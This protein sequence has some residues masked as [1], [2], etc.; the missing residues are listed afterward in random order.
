M[1]FAFRP[2]T[3]LAALVAGGKVSPDDL[4]G[5]FRDRIRRY[6][7]SLHAFITVM[8][9]TSATTDGPLAGIPYACKDMIQARGAPT[10]AGSRVLADWVP[11]DDADVVK[12]M[13]AAGAVLLGKNNQHEFAY[14]ATGENPHYGT[15]PNPY[16]LTRLAGGSSS[17]SAAAVA[18]GLVPAALGTDTG[19]SVRVPAALCGIVGFKPTL[20]LVSTEGVVPYCWTLDHVGTLTRTVGDAALLLAV[21]TGSDVAAPRPVAGMRIGLPRRHFFAHVDT[22]IVAA[23]RRVLT[24]LEGAGA[25]LVE[26]DL[27]AMDHAR[28]VSLTVQLP[29]ALSYHSRYLDSHREDYG[30]DILAGLASGQ[31]ILAEHY[32]RAKRFIHHYRAET[33]KVL[34]E[35]DVI[36]TPTTPVTAPEIGA[37]TVAGL[38]M[39]IQVVGRHFDE[40]TVLALGA[41][42]EGDP[43]CAVPPPPGF[44]E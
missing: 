17:G 25:R 6:D 16:D 44:A 9:G 22:E 19:G 20:G 42:I 28:T 32:V 34:A 2:V 29:E 21:L 1:T 4:S 41:A 31:F 37:T 26:V 5:T 23:V 8:D 36:V 14:G 35:V 33:D 30:A 3:E 43:A 11:D 39:G 24:A 13:A 7:P 10:T 15:V 38:P 18:A 40:A 12:R 27:P